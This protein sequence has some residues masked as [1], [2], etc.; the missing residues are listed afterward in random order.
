M[1]R[2]KGPKNSLLLSSFP[3]LFLVGKMIRSWEGRE[4]RGCLRSSSGTAQHTHM[5]KREKERVGR[6]RRGVNVWV[7]CPFIRKAG[8]KTLP[9]TLS[10]DFAKSLPG[11]LF[12]AAR[13]LSG[14]LPSVCVEEKRFLAC[15]IA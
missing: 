14:I 12:F 3:P 6:R 2:E 13:Q 7:S 9:F 1:E 5:G 4:G 15:K 10:P 11:A 8:E